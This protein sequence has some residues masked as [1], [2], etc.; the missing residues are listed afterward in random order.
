[1]TT[2]RRLALAGVLAL[3]LTGCGAGL[4]AMTYQERTVA[5]ATQVNLGSLAVRN[6][7][8]LPPAGGR[9][10]EAGADARGTF[11][12]VST[13]TQPDRLLE[14]TSAA[15]SE[16]VLTVDGRPGPVV[17]PP[18]G[19]TEERAAFILRGLT[20]DLGT[21]EY[22]TMTFRFE[23]AGSIEVLVPVAVTGRTQRPAFTGEPGSEEGEPALQGPAGGHHSEEEGGEGEA[24]EGQGGSDAQRGASEDGAAEVGETSTEPGEGAAEEPAAVELSP[25]G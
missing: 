8:V 23:Q 6:I 17:V 24:G 12:V 5:D 18:R 22:V 16:V 11:R 2:T 9:V 15:A 10:H 1:M 20:N 19:S 25:A 3:S 4:D 14:V 13:G 21:G 7:T